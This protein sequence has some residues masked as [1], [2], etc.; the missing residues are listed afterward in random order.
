MFI[1]KTLTK[2]LEMILSQI[3]FGKEIIWVYELIYLPNRSSKP[4]LILG[5]L[6]YSVF[7]DRGCKAEC[8]SDLLTSLLADRLLNNQI[9]TAPRGSASLIP[10]VNWYAEICEQY[11]AGDNSHSADKSPI[12]TLIYNA[13]L[14]FLDPRLYPRCSP[15]SA[16]GS[17]FQQKNR[18]RGM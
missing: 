18:L 1:S 12:T 11:L 10:K 3:N 14:N 15:G 13:E 8:F 2:V 7:K 17:A 4:D 16:A 5:D 9:A 6:F